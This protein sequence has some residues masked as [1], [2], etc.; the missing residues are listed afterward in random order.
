MLYGTARTA[1]LAR[2]Q[3]AGV[4]FTNKNFSAGDWT[5]LATVPAIAGFIVLLVGDLTVG[6]AA[7]P[8]RLG[9]APRKCVRGIMTGFI[10][11]L[12]AL[13]LVLAVSSVTESIY[14][15]MHFTHPAEPDLL[16]EMGG[17]SPF[18]RIMLIGG[19]TVSRHFSRNCFF[20]VICKPI[21]ATIVGWTMRPMPTTAPGFDVVTAEQP[22]VPPLVP[23]ATV[24]QRSI[25]PPTWVSI[26]ITSI[27]FSLVHPAWMWPPIFCLAVCLGFAKERTG[28]LWTCITMHAL[29]NGFETF[30]YLSLPHR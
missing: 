6:V 3:G 19:A 9:F 5:F 2:T 17:P 28:N 25:A 20:G 13:P 27:F 15:A 21:C 1:M 30:A 29:F 11:I 22:F 14:Q 10:G 4:P 16:R 24:R 8:A 12:I 23:F 7:M 26:V 18:I